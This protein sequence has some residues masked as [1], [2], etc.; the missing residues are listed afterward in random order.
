MTRADNNKAAYGPC[1]ATTY[2]RLELSGLPT[3]DS[4]GSAGVVM[5]LIVLKKDVYGQ[6]MAADSSSSLQV[7]SAMGGESGSNDAS[8]SFL[9]A[10]F[11]G[12]EQGRAL[13]P[14][15]VKPTFASVS[16]LE[17]RTAL[18]R[19]PF[20]YMSGTD[21]VTGAAMQTDVLEVHLA[22]HNTSANRSVCPTGYVLTLDASNAAG[23][24][25]AC[26]RC[27][28]GKYSL[29]PLVGPQ[30]VSGPGCLNCPEGASCKEGGDQV[31]FV[32][33]NWSTSNGMFVL[34]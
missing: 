17:G 27:N 15:A 8:V 19:R 4:P 32:K 30:G 29:K 9:G 28:S 23:R 1:L 13:F 34:R 3:P 18:L 10:I 6:T 11:S 25:G 24:P 7:Y 2:T 21:L 33:G 22:T 16:E 14:I 5:Q 31:S 20:L 12:F 26:T